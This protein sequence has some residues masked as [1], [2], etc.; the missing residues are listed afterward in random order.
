MFFTKGSELESDNRI[1][2]FSGKKGYEAMLSLCDQ[3]VVF[4]IGPGINEWEVCQKLALRGDFDLFPLAGWCTIIEQAA[5]KSFLPL[6]KSRGICL[7]TGG[8]HNS[9]LLTTKRSSV[10][11]PFI[12]FHAC[13]GYFCEAKNF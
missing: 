9:G 13:L 10:A 8:P 7:V 3:G 6:C 4:A 1:S 2:E 5:A 11:I 12:S